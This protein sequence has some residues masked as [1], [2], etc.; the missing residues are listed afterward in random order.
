MFRM[1]T[2][3]KAYKYS[4]RFRYGRSPGG[5]GWPGIPGKPTGAER[6]GQTEPGSLEGCDENFCAA[7]AR[8]PGSR[9][10]RGRERGRKG[11]HLW[12]LSPL[13]PPDL[14][15]TR[16]LLSLPTVPCQ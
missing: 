3:Q 14:L 4:K 10:R 8:G 16:A 5:P 6:V 12:D 7:G 2:A 13:S 15:G 11:P 9:R 1:E